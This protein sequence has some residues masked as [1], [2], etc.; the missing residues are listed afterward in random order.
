MSRQARTGDSCLKMSELTTVKEEIVGFNEKAGYIVLIVL[1]L[2]LHLGSVVHNSDLSKELNSTIEGIE[3][4]VSVEN[5]TVLEFEAT[6]YAI[7]PPYNSIARN[8]Q[9]V[10]NLGFMN[11]GGMDIFTVAAD[12][13]VLPLNSIIYIE[14]LGLGLVDDTG[15]AIRGMD[16]DICFRTMDKAMEFGRQKVKVIILKRNE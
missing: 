10:V 2:A 3:L 14:G 5:G 6:G 4:N 7:G 8:G 15:P 12:P 16:L 11:I 9:P 1:I 13:R